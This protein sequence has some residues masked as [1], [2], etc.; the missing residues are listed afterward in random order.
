MNVIYKNLFPD[1]KNKKNL[2]FVKC[3]IVY[4]YLH[5]HYSFD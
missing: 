4:K 5:I 1:N 2:M 3:F